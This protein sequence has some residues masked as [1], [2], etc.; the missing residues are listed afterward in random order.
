MTQ[1]G[2]NRSA[3]FVRFRAGSFADMGMCSRRHR[4]TL[5]A[6]ASRQATS[7]LGRGKVRAGALGVT[8]AGAAAAGTGARA[9]RRRTQRPGAATKNPSR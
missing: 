5:D 6:I 1:G 4:R 9:Q 7:G 8:A 3:K 2:H